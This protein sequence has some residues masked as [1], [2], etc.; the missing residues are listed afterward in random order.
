[1]I[2]KVNLGVGEMGF[3]FRDSHVSLK[4]FVKGYTV[5]KFALFDFGFSSNTSNSSLKETYLNLLPLKFKFS[6]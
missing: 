4:R 3:V 2:A 6:S 1:M 5:D